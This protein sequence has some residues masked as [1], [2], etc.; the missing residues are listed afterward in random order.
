MAE[1]IEAIA[2]CLATLCVVLKTTIAWL[3]IIYFHMEIW[4]HT[5]ISSGF[6]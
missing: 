6:I 1:K 3:L 5:I 4:E 2:L